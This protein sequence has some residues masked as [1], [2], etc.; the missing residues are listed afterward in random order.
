MLGHSQ[1]AAC[2][3]IATFVITTVNS[4]FVLLSLS[5]VL[6]AESVRTKNGTRYGVPNVILLAFSHDSKKR[7]SNVQVKEIHWKS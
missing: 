5:L 7:Q 3:L 4:R 6:S 2:C 1:D